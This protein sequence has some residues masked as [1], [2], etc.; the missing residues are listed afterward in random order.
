MPDSD[1]KSLETLRLKLKEYERTIRKMNSDVKSKEF[2]YSFSHKFIIPCGREDLVRDLGK[3]RRVCM[4]KI[5]SIEKLQ[6]LAE[7]RKC[8]T[9]ANN[10][11]KINM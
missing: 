2:L 10:D 8:S 9:D 4:K 6:K 5:F 7:L 3:R 1:T 11:T